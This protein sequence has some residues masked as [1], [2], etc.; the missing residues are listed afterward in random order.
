MGLEALSRGATAVVAVELSHAAARIILE[1]AKSLGAEAETRIA[2]A[3]V[4]RWWSRQTLDRDTSWLIFCCPP[5]ALFSEKK[6]AMM[7][8]VSEIIEYAP[9]DSLIVL[10]FDDRFSEDQLPDRQN[11]DVRRYPPAVIA[12]YEKTG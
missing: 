1:N 7:K 2:R 6:S 9:L 5:Y 3:D 12:V 8:L 11:W 10:E 4:F